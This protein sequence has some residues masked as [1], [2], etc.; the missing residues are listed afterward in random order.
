MRTLPQG[1][2]YMPRPRPVIR[3]PAHRRICMSLASAFWLLIVPSRADTPAR[4]SIAMIPVVFSV[5]RT[6]RQKKKRAGLLVDY[7]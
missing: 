3:A 1:R 5:S 4:P 7:V 2:V 6:R